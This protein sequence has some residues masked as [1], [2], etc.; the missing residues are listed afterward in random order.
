MDHGEDRGA[1]WRAGLRQN[2]GRGGLCLPTRTG[3]SGMVFDFLRRAE[4]AVPEQKASA[5]GRV[6]AFGSSGRVVSM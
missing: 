5:T 2:A 6:M 3:E 4:R 1:R